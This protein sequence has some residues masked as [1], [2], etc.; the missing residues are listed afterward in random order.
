MSS[1]Y[2]TL[3][4][5]HVAANLVWIGAILSVALALTT[6][7]A[8]AR[9]GAQIA[10]ELYRKRAPRTE[11][12]RENLSDEKGG[13]CNTTIQGESIRCRHSARGCWG[14]VRSS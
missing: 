6:R 1:V 12:F 10:Y 14:S 11:A 2:Q 7:V 5:A 9:A 13:S 8:D 4:A 3:V